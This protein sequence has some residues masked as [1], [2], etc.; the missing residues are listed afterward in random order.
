MNITKENCLNVYFFASIYDVNFLKAE[1]REKIC[2][3]YQAVLKS[4]DFIGLP[5]ER[6]SEILAFSD[7][8]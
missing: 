8:K 1:A 6:A 2:K 3:N 5:P 7:A 4:Q